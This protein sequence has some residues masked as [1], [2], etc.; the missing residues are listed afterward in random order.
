MQLI[1][2]RARMEGFIVVDYM[3][4]WPEGMARLSQWIAEGK[5]K[6]TVDIADGFDKTPKALIGLFSGAN[7]GKQLVKIADDPLS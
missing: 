1:M 3:S 6:E 4:R 5:L 2:K 7:M